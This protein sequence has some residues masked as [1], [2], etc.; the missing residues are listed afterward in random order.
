MM[1]IGHE[2][3]FVLIKAQISNRRFTAFDSPH[4]LPSCFTSPLFLSFPPFPLSLTPFS[5]IAFTQS[6]NPLIKNPI[7]PLTLHCLLFHF[8][9]I[10]LI[11]VPCNLTSLNLYSSTFPALSRENGTAGKECAGVGAHPFGL[12]RRVFICSSYFSCK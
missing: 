1:G 10:L 2:Q 5:I 7:K 9:P 12:V 3:N 8:K 6:P 4:P 11:R